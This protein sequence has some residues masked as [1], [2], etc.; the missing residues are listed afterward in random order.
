MLKCNSTSGNAEK[1]QIVR[2]LNC[3]SVPNILQTNNR[4]AIHKIPNCPK[5]VFLL[6]AVL[7]LAQA[8]NQHFNVD[9]DG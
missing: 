3:N 1:S 8:L 9:D 6:Y 2:M 5:I 7:N 4:T